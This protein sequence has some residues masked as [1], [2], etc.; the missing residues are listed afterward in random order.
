MAPITF[1]TEL[2]DFGPAAA[3]VL[4]DEQV[5][6]VGGGK[7]VF[8]VRL[9]VNGTVMQARLS[10][11]KGKNCIGL[12]KEKRDAAGVSAGDK[13]DVTVELDTTERTVEV[14]PALAAAFKKDKA[15]KKIY[16]GLA[17][18]HR[19]EFSRWVEEAKRDETR[20]RRVE[21]T[22]EMLHAGQTRS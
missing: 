13:V 3:V 9:T 10:R 6:E 20:E 12:S 7:K 14:P 19:K 17:F 4:T 21:K 8:P 5:A 15:A 16:D 1:K 22:L 2:S 18:T 11:M